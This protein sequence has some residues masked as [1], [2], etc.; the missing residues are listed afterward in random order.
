MLLKKGST[1]EDVKKLQSRLGVT[2]DGS[3]GP[4]TEAK[5]KEFQAANG[6]TADG[7]VGDGT[8]S[9]LFPV[10]TPQPVVSTGTLDISKLSA[11]LPAAV[12]SQLPEAIQKF[13]IN[14]A[15]RLSHFLA[16]CAHESG[17]FT[18][19]Q[20]NLNYSADGLM[21]TFKKYFPIITTAN[22]YAKQPEKI[23]NLV[24]GNRMGNGNEASGEGWKYRGRGYIQLTGKDNYTAFNKFVGDDVI[25]SPDLVATK[26]PLM[27]AGWFFSKNC[28]KK[29]DAGSS[30]E[31]I[32]SVTAC[33]NGGQIGI[34]DRIKY[35]NE[36][37]KLLA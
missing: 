25:T 3:F 31:V 15:L 17:G 26:Y 5:V 27:S 8:W 19:T 18:V 13:E 6:L 24:Y 9:K 16:Q 4:G 34:D 33:V 32:K 35:F 10:V 22:A 37:Y 12:M 2:A 21:K 29:C 11:K 30:V 28:L 20:E 14:T 1:G 23:A 7:I 36:Y